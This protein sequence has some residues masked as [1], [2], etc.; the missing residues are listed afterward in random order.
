MALSAETRDRLGGVGVST[1]TTCLFRRGFRNL[2]LR[3]LQ[4][5]APGLPPMV[6]EAT[7]LRFIPAREDI[8]GMASYSQAGNVHQAAFDECEA[9]RVLVLDTHG[10]IE[11]CSCGDLLVGRL[12]ARGA[13]GI[14]TDGGFRDTP[15]IAKLAFPAYH[16][17][18]VP[19]PSFLWLHA[20]ERD[21][22]I[23]CAGVAVFPGDIVVGDGEGVVIVPAMLADEV[24]EEAA[25]MTR[26]DAFAAAKV[27]E[28]RSVAGLY[29][30]SDAS[31][32]EYE[33]WR[34]NG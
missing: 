21:V 13:A 23:A 32:S 33:V 9:G 6:G 16:R 31:R 20:I 11:A 25:A 22:P 3:G 27:A 26:Y 29:P 4:P 19:P 8:G 12:K 30:A 5:V 17:H 28:G 1:L 24:G 34:G 10:Q 7:T 2:F 18:P 15:D 14:V